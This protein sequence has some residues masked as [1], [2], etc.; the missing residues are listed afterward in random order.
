[1]RG[2]PAVAV[3]RQELRRLLSDPSASVRVTVAHALARYGTDEDIA[4]ALRVLIDAADLRRHG[5]YVAML[6]LNALDDLDERAV[7]VEAEIRALPRDDPA[8]SRRVIQQ[9][10]RLIDK[11]VADLSTDP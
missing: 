9:F 4:L 3:A 11:T 10:G 6:A 1:M 8:A 7:A 2:G 5:V